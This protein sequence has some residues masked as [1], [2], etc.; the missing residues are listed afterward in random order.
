[1]REEIRNWLKQAEEDF[2]TAEANLKAK[3]Y[4]ACAFFSQQSAEKAAKAVFLLK[5][6]DLPRQHNLVL[7]GK[8]LKVP[9]EIMMPLVILNPEYVMTRYPDAAVGVPAEN[10]TVEI[11]K[12]KLENA[13]KVMEWAKSHLK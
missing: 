8:E 6:G 3:R 11:A 13:K 12:E 1:M 7:I 9:H 4:Y 10:Y 2:I 5:K